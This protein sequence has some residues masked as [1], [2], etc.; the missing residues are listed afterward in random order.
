MSSLDLFEVEISQIHVPFRQYVYG[1]ES[2]PFAEIKR[3]VFF[4]EMTQKI[5]EFF[6]LFLSSRKHATYDLVL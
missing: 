6:E 5:C 2:F 3:M 4:A 1:E